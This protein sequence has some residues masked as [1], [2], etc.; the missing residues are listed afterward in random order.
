MPTQYDIGELKGKR[1]ISSVQYVLMQCCEE[2][3]NRADDKYLISSC[4]MAIVNSNLDLEVRD[5]IKRKDEYHDE[6]MEKSKV[7]LRMEG[8][9]DENANNK[10][11]AGL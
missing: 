2:L 9:E 6:M 5:V 7:K 11:G 1:I 10:L 4:D 3:S 8:S